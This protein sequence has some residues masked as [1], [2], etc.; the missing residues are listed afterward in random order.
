MQRWLSI[1]KSVY[2][3]PHNDL[4]NLLPVCDLSFN[5]LNDVL[6]IIKVFNLGEFII[7]FFSGA[8]FQCSVYKLCLTLSHKDF[9]MFSSKS[10]IFQLLHLGLQFIFGQFLYKMWSRGLN[11]SLCVDIQL[12]QHLC[13]KAY[14]F[15]LNCTGTFV[16]N[17]LLLDVRVYF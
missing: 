15:L 11:S 17:Q 8:W 4:Q 12:S 6:W 7:F 16:R 3:T 1:H 2:D 10:F 13:W 9:L 14:V 5:F